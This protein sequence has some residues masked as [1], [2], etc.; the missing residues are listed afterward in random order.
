MYLLSLKLL[1]IEY[2][3]SQVP[4]ARR[5]VAGRFGEVLVIHDQVRFLLLG[6]NANAVFADPLHKISALSGF[7]LDVLDTPDRAGC[8]GLVLATLRHRL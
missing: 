5:V 1:Q 7:D 8:S 4:I 3:L 2:R 6:E